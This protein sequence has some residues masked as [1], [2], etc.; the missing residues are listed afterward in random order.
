[1]PAQL[2]WLCD[3][4]LSRAISMMFFIIFLLLATAPMLLIFKQ[5]YE[6]RR[7]V[8]RLEMEGR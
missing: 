2:V 3:Y 1:M 8:A 7:R 4:L 5:I 6:C